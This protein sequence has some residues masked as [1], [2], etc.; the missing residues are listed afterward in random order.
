[1]V[2]GSCV[3]SRSHRRGLET[4]A[5]L[6]ELSEQIGE[7]LEDV[8]LRFVEIGAATLRGGSA[9]ISVY[10]PQPDSAGIFRWAGLTGMAAPFN[11]QTTPRDFSPCEIGLDRAEGVLMRHPGEYYG[12]LNLPGVPLTEALLVPCSS[13]AKRRSVRCGSCPQ[14]DALVDD[15]GLLEGRRAL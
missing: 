14:G 6:Q 2:S 10:E 15:I 5:A 4:S 8:L 12:W 1:M 3:R 13:A 9:G 7:D 11:G